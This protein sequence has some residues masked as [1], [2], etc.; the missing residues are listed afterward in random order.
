[1]EKQ[2]IYLEP[3]RRRYLFA[4]DIPVSVS[5]V[6]AQ[7]SGNGVI[8]YN[9]RNDGRRL[10][11]T[12][13]SIPSSVMPMYSADFS[14]RR[15]LALPVDYIPKLEEEVEKITE[16]LDISQKISA[17][18]NYLSS[19][20]FEYSITEISNTPN[21]LEHFLLVNKK[22]NCEFFASAMGVMLRMAGIPSRLVGGYKGGIYNEAGGYYAVFE[23]SAHVW[24]E[25]WDEESVSWVRYDPTPYS[26]SDGS[27]LN[28]GFWEAYLDLLDYQW[29]KFVLNYNIEIQSDVMSS[30]RNIISNPGA[31]DFGETLALDHLPLA[32]G[33]FVAIILGVYFIR[34]A[35]KENMGEALPRK[36]ISIMKRKGYDKHKSEGLREFSSRLPE[37]ERIKAMAFVERFEAFYYKEKE[38]DETTVGILKES[39]K[40]LSK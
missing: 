18:S 37:R 25:L 36:F 33:L 30:V 4:L 7:I 24:V 31:L 27:G 35:M 13:A 15:Y 23:E 8:V 21:A 16:G 38:F 2:E 17:I 12:A 14:K 19:P 20:N 34:K 39:L 29:T 3:G 9:G 11:Y 5:K 40:S 32:A 28:Y 26:L 22:G 10:Q 6:E 1:M